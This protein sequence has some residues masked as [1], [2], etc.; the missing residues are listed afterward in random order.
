MR[1]TRVLDRAQ[2]LYE[3]LDFSAVRRWTA[4]AA[5]RKA[6]GYLPV[7]APREVIRAA[8]M[9]PVGIHGGGERLEIIKGDAFYQSYICHFPRSVIELAQTGRLD[10]L[11]ALL[12]PSTCDVIRNLCGVW[13]LLYPE[14][15]VR[16]L[17]LPQASNAGIAADFWK[18]E[19]A[20]LAADLSAV[21]GVAATEERLRQAIATEN[22]ARAAVR[23]LYRV[24]RETP[25]KVPTAELYV[26][27]R[28]GEVSPVEEFL[29][30]VREYLA[31]VEE[32]PGRVRDRSRVIVLGAFCEQ[33][34][35]G[36]IKTIERSGCFIV[37]DDFILGNRLISA[38]VPVEGDPLENLAGAFVRGALKTSTLFEPDPEAKSRLVAERVAAARADGV[39]F[40]SASFCDPALLDRPMLKKGAEAAGI[41]CM[42]FKFSENTGQFQQFREQAGTFADSIKLWGGA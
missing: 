13:Q 14:T 37:D 25:W 30:M 27:I 8:G 24:R 20:T 36:L 15:Y 16:Y 21:S 41:P 42:A 35:L 38:D 9:L 33:P 34:P 19:L 7:Y 5:H 4:A 11:S 2:E 12:F 28:A 32:E 40:A 29:G 23:E 6:A 26:L 3:D 31:A 1:K 39:L 10:M 17:D 18:K 22:A